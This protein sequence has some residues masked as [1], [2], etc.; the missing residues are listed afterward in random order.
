MI[1]PYYEIHEGNGLP[2]L[3]VHGI[4]SSRAQWIPNLEALKAVSSPVVVELFGHGRSVAPEDSACYH[5]D[6]YIEAFE[7]IRRCLDVT[8]WNILGYSLGAGLTIRYCINKPEAVISQLFTN[9]TSAF[10]EF[11]T[12]RKFRE[13]GDALI[14]QY[15]LQGM[16]AVESIAVHP[17][18]ARR[19]PENIRSELL[20]D[21]ELLDPVGVART[22]VYTNGNSSV[23]SIVHKN[24]VPAL[25]L[26]GEREK[27][28]SAFKHFA[29]EQMPF[30]DIVDLPAGHA[31]NMEA[32]DDFNRAV[33][34]FLKNK[35]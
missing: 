23:R 1:L 14:A 28:F 32:A 16:K 24:T 15:R 7:E 30:L 8:R 13:G 21:C 11:E 6:Y 35:V 33:T 22:I 20:Q 31:V 18:N 10:A 17:K 27:R 26:C 12:T 25:L 4:L 2:L 19:I 3:M 34:S 29:T 5:P 9:S